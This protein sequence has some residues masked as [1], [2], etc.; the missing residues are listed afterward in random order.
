MGNWLEING[1]AIYGSRPWKYQNDSLKPG[2]WYTEKSG[3]VYSIILNWPNKNLL[4]LES[5]KEIFDSSASTEI[6]L[7]G[8]SD[9]LKVGTIKINTYMSNLIYNI[10]YSGQQQAAPWIFCSQIRQQ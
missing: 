6:T 2:V 1:E 8:N 9:N 7:L 10:V 5:V 4:K 3:V